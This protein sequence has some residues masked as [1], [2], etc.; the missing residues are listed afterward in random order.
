MGDGLAL[1]R[2][3]GDGVG[4]EVVAAGSRVIEAT[5]IAIRWIDVPAGAGAHDKFGGSVPAQTMAAIRKHR[6]A[7][8][9]PFATPSGGTVRSANYYIRRELDLFACLRPFPIRPDAPP[10]VLVRENVEDLYGAIEW[11]VGDNVAQAVKVATRAGCERIACYSFDLARRCGRRTVTVVHKANNLKLT[12]GMF[13][14][15]TTEVAREYPDIRLTDM[16][17]DTAAATL[18]LAPESF[19]VILTSNTIGDILSSVGAARSGSLG[20][21]GSLNSGNGIH[22]GE[23]GH[24]D[25]GDLAGLNRV[26]PVA[27]FEGIELLL[28]EVGHVKEATWVAQALAERRRTGPSTLDLGGTAGTSQVTDYVCELIARY[29]EA[30]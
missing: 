21:V 29:R 23:A 30:T 13:L 10:A 8:K 3:A 4:P 5:G 26:N 6:A 2:I 18:V 28:Q 20:L 19:D 25:A 24:G 16:L 12:E 17:A 11:M 1:V 15:V 14:Q 27:L 22:V 9:G 7:I